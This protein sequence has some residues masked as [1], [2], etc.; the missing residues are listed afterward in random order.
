[1]KVATIWQLF[2]HFHFKQYIHES[3]VMFE[4]DAIESECE[5]QRRTMTMKRLKFIH[6]LKIERKS[7]ECLL[8]A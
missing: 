5:L 4:W 2:F 6:I 8:L 1:M 7:D 3:F